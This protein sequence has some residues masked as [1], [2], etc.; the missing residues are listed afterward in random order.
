MTFT[1]LPIHDLTMELAAARGLTDLVA[2]VAAHGVA[3]AATTYW[4]APHG[5]YASSGGSGTSFYSPTCDP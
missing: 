4:V 1:N 3:A 5:T 2:Y